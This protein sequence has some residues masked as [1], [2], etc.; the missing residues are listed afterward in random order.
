MNMKKKINLLYWYIFL[1]I[2]L[3]II[4]K[5]FIWKELF[6]LNLLIIIIFSIPFSII[7]YLISS[8][9][10]DVI[11]KIIT[12][13]ISLFITILFIAQYIYFEFYKSIFSIYSAVMGSKQVFGEFGGAVYDYIVRYFYVIIIMLIPIL[14]FVFGGLKFF[15]FK[16]TKLKNNLII[17]AIFIVVYASNFVI[18]N[19]MNKDLYSIKNLYNDV[20]VPMLTINKMGLLTMEK[21][22][23]KRYIFG[24]ENELLSFRNK[25][26]DDKEKEYNIINSIDFDH[27]IETEQNE[28]IKD[29]H[30]YF[31]NIPASNKNEFTGILKDKNIIFITAES[32]DISAINEDITPTLYKL[33]TNSLVFENYY[34]PLYS[35]STSDGEYMNLNSL[36]PK[37]SAWSFYDSSNNYMPYSL[38]NMF[39]EENYVTNAYHNH[40]Y[41]YYNRYLSHKNIGFNFLACGNGL[42]KR[43]NCNIFPESDIEMIDYTVEDYINENR[44]ATYYMT[45]SGHLRY[46]MDNSIVNKNIDK[47]KNLDYSDHV[48]NYLATQIELDKA[49]EDLILYL[50]A[51]NKYENTLIVI[52]PDHY[53]YGLTIKELNEI[54]KTDRS[55]KFELYHTSLIMFNPNIETTIVKDYVSSLDIV[56][57]IYNLFGLNYDSRLLMGTDIFSENEKIVMLSDRSWI[58]NKGKFDSITN[59]F[60]AFE[61]VSDDYVNT[62]NKIV[63]QKFAVSSLILDNDYYSRLGL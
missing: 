50:K 37:E 27:L 54:S 21:L 60:T 29:M 2:F 33:L 26:E 9:F 38:G 42:E 10:K 43:I 15:E 23:V 45:V 39:K 34:Q 6:D 7:F 17:V 4:Y 46:N 18:I 47:V 24:F 57:T 48:L 1:I 19:T 40:S 8:L 3:E 14:F 53:P 13:V 12:I 30:A 20:H 32:L 11:N 62:I 63:Y 61:K 31:N 28:V 56:P 55:D 59:E 5:V 35:V 22:D 16:R 44:F 49:I 41:N 36:L 51:N 58:T 25:S 52:A